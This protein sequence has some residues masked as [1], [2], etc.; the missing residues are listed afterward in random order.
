MLAIHIRA[1]AEQLLLARLQVEIGALD[2]T[3]CFG[4][5]VD[6]GNVQRVVTIFPVRR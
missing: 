6:H 4:G 3:V 2:V 5:V 1:I